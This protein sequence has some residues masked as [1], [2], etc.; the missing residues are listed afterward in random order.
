[1]MFDPVPHW[2]DGE[3]HLGTAE[4]ALLTA[5]TVL[6]VFTAAEGAVGVM[7]GSIAV[8]GDTI[9]HFEQAAVTQLLYLAL[10][11]QPRARKMVALPLL[12]LLLGLFDLLIVDAWRGM[13]Q[14][15]VPSP[16]ALALVGAAAIAVDILVALVLSVTRPPAV[17]LGAWVRRKLWPRSLTAAMVVLAALGTW[18]TRSPWPDLIVGLGIAV[19][20]LGAARAIKFAA[21]VR[22]TALSEGQVLLSPSPERSKRRGLLSTIFSRSRGRAAPKADRKEG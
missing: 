11:W 1:M 9:A 5:L 13:S 17:T 2:D 3:G 4:D 6:Y 8:I 16:T 20:S 15:R 21:I 18:A 7:F 19:S 14:F 12:A 10:I 22:C